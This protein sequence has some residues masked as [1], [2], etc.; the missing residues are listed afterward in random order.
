MEPVDL[1]SPLYGAGLKFPDG[2]CQSVVA[3]LVAERFGDYIVTSVVRKQLN[4][5]SVVI[6]ISNIKSWVNVSLEVVHQ[7]TIFV[8]VSSE[9]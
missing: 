7:L 9:Q 8:F 6:A 3:N 1:S 2:H 5:V 4:A